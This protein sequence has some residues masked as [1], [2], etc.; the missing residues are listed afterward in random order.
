MLAYTR[1]WE[2]HRGRLHDEVVRVGKRGRKRA[3][4]RRRLIWDL[5]WV[6]DRL[7]ALSE[8]G[9]RGRMELVEVTG[10]RPRSIRLRGTR[11][12]RLAVSTTGR[13]AYSYGHPAPTPHGDRAT[14]WSGAALAPHRLVPARVGTGRQPDPRPVARL[15]LGARAHGRGLR[16]GPTA[17]TS[18]LRLRD[19][20]AVDP[21]RRGRDSERI[22]RV[23]GPELDRRDNGN[24]ARLSGKGGCCPGWPG[25]CAAWARGSLVLTVSRC[26]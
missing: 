13:I 24:Q 5:V 22:V 25:A 26:F 3:L 12:G 16:R 17:G 21:L 9:R 20:G 4:V 2:D 15:G 23:G 14:G 8:I 19:V 1:L 11:V 18:R 7:F 6:G 10:S